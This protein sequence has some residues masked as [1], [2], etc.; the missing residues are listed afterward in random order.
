[1]VKQINYR[2]AESSVT[3]STLQ[4]KCLQET[5]NDRHMATGGFCEQQSSPGVAIHPDQGTPNI[6][7][8]L[9]KRIIHLAKKWMETQVAVY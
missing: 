8:G 3:K 6:C 2:K 7:W 1:M 4:T 9:T 5:H